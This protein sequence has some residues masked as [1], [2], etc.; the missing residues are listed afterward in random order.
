MKIRL[1]TALTILLIAGCASQPAPEISTAPTPQR[2]DPPVSQTV[3]PAAK[4]PSPQ[5]LLNAASEYLTRADE[6]LP[7]QRADFQLKAA[8]ALVQ[9]GRLDPAMRLLDSIDLTGLASAYDTRRRLLKARISLRSNR[10]NTA[11]VFL[12]GLEIRPGLNPQLGGQLWELRARANLLVDRPLEAVRALIMRER[13]LT[14]PDELLFNQRQIWALLSRTKMNQLLDIRQSAISEELSGWIDLA[15]AHMEYGHDAFRLENEIQRWRSLHPRHSADLFLRRRA[16]AYTGPAI[17]SARR[18]ALLLPLASQYGRAAQAVHDGF[19]AVHHANGDPNK[20]EIAVYDIGSEATLSPIYYRL[21]VQ[22]GADLVVG[23]LGKEA[24][25]ALLA[26]DALSVPTLLLGGAS[27]AE[28]LPV[29]GFQFDLSPEQD[30]EQ[31]ALRAYLDGHRTAAVLYPETPW[32][33]R[34]QDAFSARWRELGGVVVESRPYVDNRPDYSASIKEVLNIDKSEGRKYE[35]SAL[36]GTKLGFQ[37]RRRQDI[38]FL[39][40][41]AKTSTAR[42]LKPQINFFQA[43]DLP[44]YATSHVY[45]GKQDPVNDIDLNGIV[46]VYMTWFLENVGRIRNTRKQIQGSWPYAY[47]ALDRLFALGMDSYAIIP[48]LARLREDQD[49]RIEGVTADLSM[50]RAG[51]VIRH[52]SWAKFENGRPVMQELP[53]TG[54]RMDAYE[55]R[56]EASGT[57]FKTRTAG[58]TQGP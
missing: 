7:P 20:P 49:L 11:F 26:T 1:V 38:D 37:P 25:A 19:T 57:P 41:A 42:L 43:H 48:V 50:D 35:L 30:A 58:G 17:I 52:L 22:E 15:L 12:S 51:R 8:A 31:T 36:L 46:F 2:V 5:E 33:Q 9:S 44:V 16:T 27:A 14:E 53:V 4:P 47:S 45:A 34:V 55:T 21:A 10:P 3:E 56:N 29:N 18:V 6:A 39:F 23:P 24:V 40:L 54:R 13:Y 32:G 28:T